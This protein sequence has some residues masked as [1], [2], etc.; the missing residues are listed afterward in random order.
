MNGKFNV[1]LIIV[2]GK[3]STGHQNQCMKKPYHSNLDKHMNILKM[4][5]EIGLYQRSSAT[6]YRKFYAIQR[7]WTWL[8][9]HFHT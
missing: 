6:K 4:L 3:R 5:L 7:T 1:V 8:P 9:S 2:L